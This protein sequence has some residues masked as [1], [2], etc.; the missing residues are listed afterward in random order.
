MT[1]H[2]VFY[3]EFLRK[4]LKPRTIVVGRNFHFGHK[5]AG[6]VAE[7][8]K[9]SQRDDIHLIV[10]PE[11]LFKE[12]V[13]SSTR[14][15]TCLTEAG[16]VTDAAQMLGRPFLLEG[17]IEKGDQLGRRLGVPTANL[18][19]ISQLVPLPGVY[20]GYVSL[21]PQDMLSQA[22]EKIRIMAMPSRLIPAAFSIG[23]RPTVHATDHAIRVEAHLLAGEY[24]ENS[25]YGYRAGYYFCHRLREERKFAD[26]EELKTQMLKD[27]AEARALL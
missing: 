13:V 27:L 6:T 16:N 14:I 21:V 25:L 3:E 11:Q 7:L 8:H 20:A 19:S 23:Y 24:G 15:R 26:L 2:D 9:Y 10:E 1:P 17:V 5:K 18:G 12:S 22:A 4:K